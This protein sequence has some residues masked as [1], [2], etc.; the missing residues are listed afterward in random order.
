MSLAR[1]HTHGGHASFLPTGDPAISDPRQ[2]TSCFPNKESYPQ[3]FHSLSGGDVSGET[4]G[5]GASLSQT[6]GSR[7]EK[8]GGPKLSGWDWRG[9]KPCQ[10]CSQ[11]EKG[12]KARS[13]VC[14]L[15]DL[16]QVTLPV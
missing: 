5:P 4:C 7:E 3:P 11:R 13:A 9:S 14:Q 6:A 16:G 10:L 8:Y 2:S 12:P 15:C 1:S